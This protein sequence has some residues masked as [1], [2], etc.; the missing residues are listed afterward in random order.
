[1]LYYYKLYVSIN[2]F[3]NM[4]TLVYILEGDVVK[5][6]SVR[7]SKLQQ[8]AVPMILLPN[9]LNDSLTQY[10]T[11]EAFWQNN[12]DAHFLCWY[13]EGKP[14]R[15]LLTKGKGLVYIS[16]YHVSYCIIMGVRSL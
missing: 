11:R 8:G 14:A 7:V 13:A 1:M 9:T 16:L 12:V 15:S 6:Q 4:N 2:N 5:Q 3:F 10:P